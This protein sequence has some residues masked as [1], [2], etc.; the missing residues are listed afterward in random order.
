M[1]LHRRSLV[2]YEV[3]QSLSKHG[4]AGN[5]ETASRPL[6]WRCFV[7]SCTVSQQQNLNT[8][9]SVQAIMESSRTPSRP[10]APASTELASELWL[11]R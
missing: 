11:Y 2:L 6:L 4:C 9:A 8:S 10:F 5:Q 1:R 3:Q 7:L